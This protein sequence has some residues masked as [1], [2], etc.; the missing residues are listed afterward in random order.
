MSDAP[1]FIDHIGIDLVRAAE[2]WKRAF[3]R[4]MAEAGYPAV[5]E[6]RGVILAVI[7]P[8]GVPQAKVPEKCGITKQAV[9]QHI[10]QLEAEGLV[11][12]VSVDGDARA[13]TVVLTEAGREMHAVGNRIKREIE[14]ELSA[15]LTSARFEALRDGLRELIVK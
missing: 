1:D 13:K 9:A 12:R 15:Q 2:A 6:A 14:A 5:G 7:G 4:R 8:S 10:V 3:F 11:E